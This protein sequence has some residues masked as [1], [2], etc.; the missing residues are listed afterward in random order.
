M[1]SKLPAHLAPL[2]AQLAQRVVILDGAYGTLLQGENLVEEDYRAS[3]L[4]NHES[5]LR[6][7]YDILSVTQPQLIQRCHESYLAAGAEIIKTNSFTATT[8]AQADYALESMVTEMNQ[9]AARIARAACDNYATPQ[10]P[11]YVAGVLGPTNRTASLSPDVNDPGF[12]NVTFVE[13]VENYTMAASAL[14]DGGADL[15]LIETVFD[16]L[17]E[18]LPRVMSIG[19]LDIN[20]EGLL[21]LTN[22]GDI[23]RKLE[24]PS[25]GW[26]RRYRVRVNG[27][28]TEPMLAPLRKGITVDGERFQPMEVTLDRQQGSNAW[29]T[30]G[31]REG[32]NREI[33]RALGEVALSVNRLIRVSY[34]PFRLDDMKP[35]DGEEVRARIMREQ[36]GLE[37]SKPDALKPKRRPAPRR[38]RTGQPPKGGKPGYK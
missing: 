23:K 16:T 12:R 2:Q 11:R 28:P 14:L 25:T 13:L 26:L 22:D 21:L 8:I 37:S 30:I 3:L 10:Q 35:S 29:L 20:S 38:D 7:N 17:P 27:M 31:L 19:R 32:K 18:E 5:P 1:I 6:G 33:R 36:L 4:A 34:G 9:A 24:L 15:I